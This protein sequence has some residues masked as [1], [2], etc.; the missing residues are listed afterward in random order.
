MKMR[1][2]LNTWTHLIGIILSVAALITLV[3]TAAF[4]QSPASIVGA[5]IF[6]ISMLL[7]YS[8]STLYHWYN[9]KATTVLKLRKLD[10]AMI[11]VLIAGTYTPI[12]LVV[13]DGWL[14]TGLLIGVWTMALLGI[15]A[16]LLFIN[17]PRVLSAG[18]YLFMGWISLGF[19][20][21]LYKALPIQGF[22]WLVAG[23]LLYTVGSLFY[24]SKSERIKWG[25]WGFHEIFHLFILAGTFAHFM[26][27]QG[28]VL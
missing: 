24:A 9:G 6:G 17:M 18:I 23:G 28:Y 12:C 1:E 26:L 3:V 10:H 7:L 11:F 14:G 27:I 25:A 21:P 20:Y 16:K 22:V 4:N 19:I 8:S 15:L 5:A 13:L 2:P